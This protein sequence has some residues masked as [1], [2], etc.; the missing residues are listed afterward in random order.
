MVVSYSVAVAENDNVRCPE[1]TIQTHVGG[2][3]DVDGCAAED[4][5]G[6]AAQP[7]SPCPPV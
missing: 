5:N 7:P 6:S 1:G 2:L 4:P 3:V